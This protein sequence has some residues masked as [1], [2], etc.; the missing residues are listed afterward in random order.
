MMFLACLFV[1]CSASVLRGLQAKKRTLCHGGHDE[2]RPT[3]LRRGLAECAGLVLS[4]S[5]HPRPPVPSRLSFVL[6]GE[7]LPT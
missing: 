6:F 4:D 1:W 3:R 5:L 2:R 7:G